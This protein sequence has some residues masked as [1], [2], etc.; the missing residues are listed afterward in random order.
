M[1]KLSGGS[2][3]NNEKVYVGNAIGNG[4]RIIDPTWHFVVAIASAHFT[5]CL[6]SIHKRC[7]LPNTVNNQVTVV[8]GRINQSASSAGAREFGKVV[9]PK[10]LLCRRRVPA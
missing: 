3:V 8:N 6:E 10:W 2:L 1:R 7:L 5:P 9:T 4:V